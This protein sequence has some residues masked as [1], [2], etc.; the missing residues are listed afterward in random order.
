MIKAIILDMGGV[1][2]DLDRDRCIESFHA[3]GCAAID[4]MLDPCHQKGFFEDLETGRIDAEEFCEKVAGCC[5]PGVT[6]QQIKDAFLS[7]CVGVEP[8]KWELIRKLGEKY[9]MYVLSNNNPIVIPHFNMIGSKYGVTTET[10]FKKCFLSYEM[11]ME[12]PCKEIFE[13]AIRQIGLPAEEM[14]FVDDS[15]TNLEVGASMG[16]KTVL[17]V[18]G[19]DLEKVMEQAITNYNNKR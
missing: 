3:L 10:S 1:L 17:Y 13:T 5:N 7:F 6:H 12:K 4:E 16:M 19:D 14:L 15:A 11:H 8:Y 9:E 18:H 2:I